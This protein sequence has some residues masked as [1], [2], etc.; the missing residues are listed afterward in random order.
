MVGNMR[1]DETAEYREMLE[2]HELLQADI[3]CLRATASPQADPTPDAQ[4]RAALRQGVTR[5][6]EKLRQHFAFEEEGG[7]LEPVIAVRPGLSR[8]VFRLL[9]QHVEI[10]FELDH[11]EHCFDTAASLAQVRVSVLK[12]VEFVDQHEVEETDL[13]QQALLEDLGVGD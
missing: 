7:F 12:I 5:L 13:L 2:Q 8:T 10:L 9:Q 4:L 11:L 6:Q 1:I 3:A